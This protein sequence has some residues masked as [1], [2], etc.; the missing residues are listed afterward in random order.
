MA[1]SRPEPFTATDAVGNSADVAT[2][3]RAFG[4]A[5]SRRLPNFRGKERAVRAFE[6]YLR[7]VAP[8]RQ[9]IRATVGGVRYALQTEDLI[10]YRIAYLSAH[11]GDVIACLDGVIGDR[12]AVLWD[13][14]ANV[15]AVSL[16]LARRH[17]DLAI[18]AFEPS[19]AVIPRLRRNLALN[20]DLAARIRLHE[21]AL[22]DRVGS[23]DF[24]PS[25]ESGNG[26]VGTLMRGANTERTPVRVSAQAGDALIESGAARPPDVLKIDVEGFE[27]EVLSGLRRHLTQRRDL[28]V[29]FEHEPYR[30]RGRPESGKSSELLSA[31]GFILFG[32]TRRGEEEPLRPEMLERHMDIVARGPQAMLRADGGHR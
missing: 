13:V 5:V 26:G 15:G 20:D 7:R 22:C 4:A 9:V 3:L 2:R 27:Y 18:E 17:P 8:S 19:P 25:A 12:N 21:I 10:D 31:M 28:V 6:A 16:P 29:I 32:L 11:A 30:L 24:Y 1:M 23:V 14:G